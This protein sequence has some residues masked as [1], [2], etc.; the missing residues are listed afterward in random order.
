LVG[1]GFIFREKNEVRVEI[2]GLAAIEKL[3]DE[4]QHLLSVAYFHGQYWVF[5]N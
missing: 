5:H 2:P 1:C 3:K 4:V